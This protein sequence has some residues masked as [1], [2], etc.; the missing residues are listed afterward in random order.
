MTWILFFVCVCV[1]IA[2]NK[3][4]SVKMSFCHFVISWAFAGMWHEWGK[5]LKVGVYFE[6]SDFICIFAV[7]IVK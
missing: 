7:E 4:L 1:G 2:L 6:H 5:K 3:G